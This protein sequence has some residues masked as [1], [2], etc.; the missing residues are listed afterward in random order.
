MATWSTAGKARNDFADMIDSL[1]P[2]QLDQQSLCSD[3]TA[4]GVLAHVTS[5]VETNAVSFFVSMA[6]AGFDFDKTSIIMANKQLAR[7]VEE[8]VAT[9]RSKATKSAP[10]PMFPESMTV[11]DVVIHSQDIRRPLG[12]DSTPDEDLVRKTLDFLTTEKMATTLV[13]RRPIEGV[14]LVANDMQWTFGDGAEINGPAEAILMALANRP[15]L[16]DLSGE[17]LAAW[18]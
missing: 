11:A 13:E 2:E 5:F 17:G 9:L 1:S 8:V 7:P 12:L 14:Q 4:R 18:E 3:W 16:G 10:L 6:K 15:V